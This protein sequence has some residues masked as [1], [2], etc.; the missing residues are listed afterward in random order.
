MHQLMLNEEK[1]CGDRRL[2]ALCTYWRPPQANISLSLSVIQY[3]DTVRLTVMADA[4]LTPLQTVPSKRWPTAI[5]RFN[6]QPG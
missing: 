4:R 5:K 1:H 3:A 6:S 2:M